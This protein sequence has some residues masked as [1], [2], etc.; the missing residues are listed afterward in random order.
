M[1]SAT[2]R[3]GVLDGLRVSNEGSGTDGS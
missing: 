2:L 1:T 3:S